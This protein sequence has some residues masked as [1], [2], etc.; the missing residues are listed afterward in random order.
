MNEDDLM[1]VYDAQINQDYFR[2]YQ[3]QTDLVSTIGKGAAAAVVDFGASVWNSLPVTP[4][5]QTYDLLQNLDPTIA[6][7]YLDN[8]DAIQTASFIGGIFVPGGLALKGMNML[9][10]GA[11]GASWFSHEGRAAKLAQSDELFRQGPAALKEYRALKR[12]LLARNLGN[13]LLDAAAMEVA[14]LGTLNAHPFMED[15]LENPVKNFGIS[16][17]LGGAIGGGLGHIADRFAIKQIEG[18]AASEAWGQI[19]EKTKTVSEGLPFVNRIQVQQENINTLRALN[20]SADSN[21]LLK[22][23]SGRLLL[24][25]QADQA[26][27]FQKLATQLSEDLSTEQRNAFIQVLAADTRFQGVDAIDYLRLSE[28]NT[29]VTWK[30]LSSNKASSG[31]I[32]EQFFDAKGRTQVRAYSPEFDLFGSRQDIAKLS[33]A[34]ALGETGPSIKAKAKAGPKVLVPDQDSA[35]EIAAKPT[36]EVDAMFLR[37]LAEVDNIKPEAFKI[38]AVAP[39]DLPTLQAIVARAMKD[40]EVFTD[41]KIKVTRATPNY[42]EVTKQVFKAGGVSAE[43]HKKLLEFTNPT[44]IRQYDL[45]GANL[46]ADARS[47]LSGW[48]AGNRVAE[49]RTAADAYFRGGYGG[50]SAMREAVREMYE[51]PQSVALRA[52]F[53]EQADA[54]GNVYLWRGMKVNP[55]GH[56]ALESYTTDIAKAKEF[57]I[58]RLFKVH[59]DDIL[60][61]I[62]DLKSSDG[63]MKNEII[64]G[65]PARQME[66]TLPVSTGTLTSAVKTNMNTST[67]EMSAAELVGLLREQKEDLIN[68]M[69]T[70]GIPFE[71]IAIRTNV[72][73]DTVKAYALAGGTEDLV[74]LEAAGFPWMQ[75][76]NIEDLDSYVSKSMAPMRLRVNRN[77]VPFAEL[78]AEL[79]RKALDAAN[80]EIVRDFLT[81]SQSPI[82]RE[83]GEKLLD[84]E[85]VPVLELMRSQVSKAINELAGNKFFQSTD[86]F[87]RNMGDFGK[88]ASV[89][90][91]D[92]QHTTNKH[93]K[94]ILAPMSELM[95]NVAKNEVTLTELNTAIAVNASLRGKRIYKEGQFFQ[96]AKVIRD[97][98]EVTELVPVL[99]QGQPFKVVSNEVDQLLIEFGKA[100]EEIYALKN[101]SRKIQGI[102]DM[103]NNGFWVPPLNPRGKHIAYVHNQVDDTTQI[104]WGST[105]TELAEMVATFKTARAS[106]L[107]NG[108][109]RIVDSKKDQELFNILNSRQDQILMQMADTSKFHSG[110]SAPAVVRAN[111][112]SLRDIIQGYEGVL[113]NSI[114]NIAEVSMSDIT[115]ALHKISTINRWGTEN[116]PLGLLQKLVGQKQD[117]AQIMRNTLLGVSN[118]RDDA[119]WQLVNQ[120][121]ETVLGVASSTFGKIWK[122]ATSP[123][124]K[125]GELS[126]ENLA[127]LDYE[128]LAKK[129]EEAGIVNPWKAFDDEAA[130]LYGLARIS[131][132]KDL[133]RRAVY[134]SNALAA[135]VALRFGEIAQPVVNAMS[136]PILTASAIADRL[137][138]TFLG[139]QKSTAKINPVQAMYEGI[140]A[141]FGSNPQH[142]RWAKAWEEAG[143]FDA[144]VSEASDVLKLGRSFEKGMLPKLEN[145][146]DSTLV[147][148]MSK[149]ADASEAMVRR[150]AMFTGGNLAKRLYPELSDT[151]ITIFARDF[152]DKTIGNYHAA[153]R[154]TMFQGTLGVAM[155]LFQ[156]YMVTMA[157]SLYRHV[158]LKNF[159]AIASTM[160]AQQ[161]IFG[162]GSLPGFAP[163][164]MLIGEHFSD[165]NVDLITGTY[166]ALPDEMANVVLYGLP[167]SM[168]PAFYTR[169]ELAP[170]VPAGIGEFPSVNMATQAITAVTEIAK[171]VGQADE[172]A[173]RAIMQ[174]LSMQSLSRPLARWSELASGYAVTRQGNTIATPEEVWTPVGIMSRM[175]SMR[176]L[177][178]AKLRD[179]IHFNTAYGSIDREA[180]Q[181]VTARLKTALRNDELSNDL[182]ESLA[183]EYLRTGTPS[184]WRSALNT[185]IAQT[186]VNGKV[187]LLDKMKPDSPLNH[188][189]DSLDGY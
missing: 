57:G 115:D 89:I 35:F 79:D 173:G 171:S 65:S 124:A 122:G 29:T 134:A 46:S 5:V 178:E 16:L 188:M 62:A 119:R 138:A 110:A 52:K 61:S 93:I 60:G 141:A 39:D 137:P 170:R 94:R 7:V 41:L 156:T 163:I 44:A 140:R 73:H 189:I 117:S 159:K 112:D 86:F 68:S 130:K 23:Y 177:E 183:E 151:G 185:A 145:A 108:N 160:L 78:S 144:L 97:G 20:Q 99:Y 3:T 155:G 166:R 25:A 18:A 76:R 169:G 153:Q 146:L 133:S 88:V 113:Q 104:L 152:M 87:V 187:P 9:R 176:P 71:T 172:N 184:G 30:A 82:A 28:A 80:R 101:T 125:K 132:S 50:R 186:N 128:K 22:D 11:K 42:D 12:E 182:L 114:R 136:L 161:T 58:P 6:D 24:Q 54:E 167:S 103:P 105:D 164:S 74:S 102:S 66:A 95:D 148:W 77:K 81:T 91:K 90:G 83:L 48:R 143:Y 70:Q 139:V 43:H 67:Q 96:E 168:G 33:R 63:L 19:L 1:E 53:K 56:A 27:D 180:R 37:K 84:G 123:F 181:K 8:T 75:Y 107:A 98:Q 26:T 179:A 72:P 15:Y 69:I 111:V 92:I 64:V 34:S 59:V 36:A 31:N 120:S 10:N 150:V 127:K 51:S 45:F 147:R 100:G 121:F 85:M 38:S 175:M 2:K 14:I 126:A 135:T 17:A 149:P 55:R 165:D 116:Q 129:L 142:Q 118:L 4:E 174:A 158:E 109:L 106:D 162:A 157:Q 32:F 47:L 49:M 21:G 154:P 131:E 13:N 40:P